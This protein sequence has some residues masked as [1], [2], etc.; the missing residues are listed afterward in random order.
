MAG[1]FWQLSHEPPCRKE[2]QEP[3]KL[4]KKWKEWGRGGENCLGDEPPLKTTLKVHARMLNQMALGILRHAH[5]QKPQTSRE[6]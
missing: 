2:K 3:V 4:N 5:M 6:C 1:K